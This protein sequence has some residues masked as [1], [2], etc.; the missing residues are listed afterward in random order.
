M[1]GPSLIRRL[2]TLLG[3]G[4]DVVADSGRKPYSVDGLANFGAATEFPADALRFLDA[5]IT[6][7]PHIVFWKDRD[8]VFLGC[9]KNF[10]AIRNLSDSSEVIGKKLSD[11]SNDQH[12]ITSAGEIDAQVIETGIP[13]LNQKRTIRV[14]DGREVFLETSKMPIRDQSGNIVGMVG[15]SSDITDKEMAERGLQLARESLE[16]RVMERTRKLE[17]EIS[18]KVVAEKALRESEE[19]FR[20]F[21]ISCSDWLW[22]T[23]AKGKFTY[24]SDRICDVLGWRPGEIIDETHQILATRKEDE[25]AWAEVQKLIRDGQQ[26][27]DLQIEVRDNRGQDR[28]VRISG[29]PRL[30]RQGKVLEFR[31]AGVDV[32]EH[33]LAR[34]REGEAL[35]RFLAAVETVPVAVAM[36]DDQNR[37]VL[38][39]ERFRK[40]LMSDHEAP[41]GCTYEEIVRGELAAGAVL[42]AGGD[43]EAWVK[44]RLERFGKATGATLLHRSN[45][46]FDVATHMTGDGY[47]LLFIHDITERME[48]EAKLVS[49]RDELELRVQERTRALEQEIFE[50]KYTQAEL[51]KA[52]EELERRVEERTRH[53]RAEMTERRMAEE[54]FVQAQKMEAVG[55]LAGGIAHDFNNLLTVIMGN[56]GWLKEFAGSDENALRVTD[57]ALEGARRAG[58]L[59]QRMLAFS[60]QQELC[61]VDIDFADLVGSI[62]PLIKRGLREDISFETSISPDLWPLTADH[63]QLENALLN[64]AIN[65]RDAMPKGGSVFLSAENCVID[66]DHPAV[67]RD[68]EAG[69]YVVLSM[70]D[71]GGGISSRHLERVFDPFYT[72]KKVGK[73]SGLGLSMVFGFVNQSGGF[74]DIESEVGKGT[75]V[76]LY[77]RRAVS[78]PTDVDESTPRSIVRM[79]R[80]LKVLVV[81]DDAMVRDVAVEYLRT[82]GIEAR[83]ACDGADAIRSLEDDG[84]V[85]L[86]VSDV[87]MPGLNGIELK[88]IIDERWPKTRFLLMSGYSFDEF[89]SRGIT[90]AS[91]DLLVKPF[92]KAQFLVKIGEVMD[93]A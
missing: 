72:T 58:E 54:K 15:I 80:D 12:E 65:A 28:I 16:Q 93:G 52:N 38:R 77:L 31:G 62:E 5:V 41:L 37:L 45:G 26:F 67:A 42:D 40:H 91:V 20:E 32:T 83:E 68:A 74:I 2:K 50:R 19:R 29:K 82:A 14:S 39:N 27:R 46:W 51:Q 30:S 75:A 21:A 43:V 66:E 84:Q 92:S 70:R 4:S 79:G 18:E 88:E 55:Q 1:A 81:E 53:L 69:D 9:N 89:T 87:I 11:I 23:D 24:V 35:E 78:Q 8:G 33:V 34:R 76:N 56:L 61:P 85:D 36:F 86:V 3:H 47:T 44:S 59:T 10:L 63:N 73:G 90:H 48:A 13:S 22:E 60:R 71:T 6:N 17:A 64:I 25:S 7:T 57:L 49:A